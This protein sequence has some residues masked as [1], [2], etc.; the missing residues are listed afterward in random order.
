VLTAILLLVALSLVLNN[1]QGAG[2]L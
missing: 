2:L 1:L